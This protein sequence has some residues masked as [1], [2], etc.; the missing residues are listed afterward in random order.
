MPLALEFTSFSGWIAVAPIATGVPPTYFKS[1]RHPGGGQDLVA[2]LAQ[3]PCELLDKTPHPRAAPERLTAFTGREDKLWFLRQDAAQTGPPV[4]RRAGGGKAR[5]GA[6]TMRARS[7]HAHGCAFSE[8]RSTLA[9][10]EGRM[11]EERATG[12]VLSL[13]TFFAQA[14]KV[15]RSPAG[16]VEALHFSRKSKWMTSSAVESPACAGMTSKEKSWMTS[17]AVESL[18][19]AGMTS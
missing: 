14:K 17:S 8:P 7:L 2:W 4:A 5:R 6:R 12:G 19:C 11:P 16:R 9:H 10:S 3:S 15:T 1:A 13:V 18:A